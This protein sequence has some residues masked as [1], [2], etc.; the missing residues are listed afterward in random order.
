MLNALRNLRYKKQNS[1]R[2]VSRGDCLLELP[3]KR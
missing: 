3:R 2:T 1:R